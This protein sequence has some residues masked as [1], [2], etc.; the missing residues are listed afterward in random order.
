MLDHSTQSKTT[1]IRHMFATVCQQLHLGDGCECTQSQVTVN[2][3]LKTVSC[4]F[5]SG[6]DGSFCTTSVVISKDNFI[7][8]IVVQPDTEYFSKPE[9]HC[10]HSYEQ[11]SEL[12]DCEFEP[13]DLSFQQL[14]ALFEDIEFILQGNDDFPESIFITTENIEQLEP[15]C[16][17]NDNLEPLTASD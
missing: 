7:G 16:Q 3:I 5:R 9:L 4:S 17:F 8:A 1:S 15:L 2:T 14:A 6:A 13:D 12:I 11:Y 10:F